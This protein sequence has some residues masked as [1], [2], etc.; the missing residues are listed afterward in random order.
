MDILCQVPIY[1]LELRIVSISTSKV[2]SKNNSA[3]TLMSENISTSIVEEATLDY[4]LGDNAS[5]LTKLTQ[6]IEK[7]PA[8]CEAWHALTEVY[9]SVRDLG[10]ALESAE[11]A[12]KLRPKDVHIN[13]SL[14]RIWM[15]KGDKATAEKFGAEARILGWK[16]ELKE[17]DS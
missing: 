3:S 8:C 14:S 2:G 5:A 13:T 15:E 9:F 17:T 12:Y 11:K 7:D 1:L 6:V 10:R 4:T 16:T